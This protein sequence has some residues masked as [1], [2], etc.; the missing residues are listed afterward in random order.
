MTE[1]EGLRKMIGDSGA[2][3]ELDLA[4]RVLGDGGDRQLLEPGI[5]RAFDDAPGDPGRD[6]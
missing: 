5:L 3:S 4:E 6:G 1:V 2:F